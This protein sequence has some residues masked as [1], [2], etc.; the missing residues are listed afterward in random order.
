MDSEIRLRGGIFIIESEFTDFSERS[1]S[2]RPFPKP[3]GSGDSLVRAFKVMIALDTVWLEV[4]AEI[5][6]P[7]PS[8]LFTKPRVVCIINLCDL[9]GSFRCQPY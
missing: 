8:F 2:K 3:G 5:N 4:P 7:Y 1:D 6:S 9:R